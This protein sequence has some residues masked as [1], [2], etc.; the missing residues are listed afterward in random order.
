M[1]FLAGNKWCVGRV[2]WNKGLKVWTGGGNK[3]GYI[4]SNKGVPMSEKQ[5]E[6]ISQANKGSISWNKGKKYP[7]IC[8][9]KHWNWKGGISPRVM[10]SPEYKLW[11]KSVFERDDYVCRFCG[12]RGGY[13]E[14]D[15]IKPWALY[16]ELRFAIDNGRTLCRKCHKTTFIFFGNKYTKLNTL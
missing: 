5:K 4:P 15:H 12:Q 16:P 11:R 14:A 2:P 9:E 10:N 8:G 1:G 13:L 7:Q 3:R 6:K